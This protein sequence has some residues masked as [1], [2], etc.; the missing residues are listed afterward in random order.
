[1]W[2]VTPSSRW[3]WAGLRAKV[4][5]FGIRNSLLLAPMPTASTAQIM[6]KSILFRL[7]RLHPRLHTRPSHTHPLTSP[8]L[9]PNT[10]PLTYPLTLIS[11]LNYTGNNESTE[12]FTS[13]TLTPL[14]HPNTP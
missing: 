5:E 13:N 9:P 6:G 2:G 1:M 10:P 4:A 8:N 12:P 11:L 3:D 14:T 7:T